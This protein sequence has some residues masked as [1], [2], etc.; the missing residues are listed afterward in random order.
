[1]LAPETRKLSLERETLLNLRAP[2]PH[3]GVEAKP[4]TV[5]TFSAPPE[6]PT[7]N[8]LDSRCIC[9]P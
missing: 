7:N 3:P 9:D 1:M 8:P 5:P 6:C 4:T 2:E